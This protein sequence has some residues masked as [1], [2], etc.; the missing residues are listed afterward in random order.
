MD[1]LTEVSGNFPEDWQDPLDLFGSLFDG[2][3]TSGCDLDFERE[4]IKDLVSLYGA[5]WVW[6][7]RLQLAPMVMALKKY[8]VEVA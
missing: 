4:N 5:P 3:R 6:D 8:S 7:N 2:L 1:F